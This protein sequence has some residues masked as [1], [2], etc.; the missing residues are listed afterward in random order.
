MSRRTP[1]LQPPLHTTLSFLITTSSTA[2]EP[3]IEPPAHHLE[4]LGLDRTTGRVFV[5]EHSGATRTLAVIATHGGAAG[6]TIPLPASTRVAERPLVPLVRGDL[7]G[8]ELVTRVM[9][10]RGLRVVGDA[11]P[12]RKFALGITVQ[13]RARGAIVEHGRAVATAYLRPRAALR[14]VW[15]VP[16]APIAIAIVGYCGVPTGVGVDRELAVLA[17]PSWH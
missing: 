1:P 7:R 13:R 17:T 5:R 2:R 10:R 12:V 11:A 15:Q 4:P 9:Q 3:A 6:A 8:W 16:G 14:A